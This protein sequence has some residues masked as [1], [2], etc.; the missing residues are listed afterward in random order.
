MAIHDFD[1]LAST[2]PTRT[3]LDRLREATGISN[4]PMERHCLR[5]RH[6]AAAIASRRGWGIDEEVLT[7]AAIL[8]DIGLYPSVASNGV[9]TAD[10]AALAREL[11][12]EHGWPHERIELCARAIDRHHDM[13]P[14]LSYGP[15][16]EAL[17][18]ADRVELTAGLLAAGLDRQWLRVLATSV[19][20]AGLAAELAREITRAI[21]DRP[22]TLPRIFLRP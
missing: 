19:P 6:I 20:R 13:R 12:A 1:T 14:Q 16:I 9:Y 15:E 21:R 5:C 11:L 3:A 8:H 18:L 10:G 22:L 17:R 2:P 7:V 4:G